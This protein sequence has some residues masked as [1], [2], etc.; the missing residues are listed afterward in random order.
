MSILGIRRSSTFHPRLAMNWLV[1]FALLE[2]A[3]A[4]SGCNE[5]VQAFEGLGFIDSNSHCTSR[6]RTQGVCIRRSGIFQHDSQ[7][8]QP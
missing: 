5:V 2:A 6:A 8:P 3:L 4:G 1:F 7:H